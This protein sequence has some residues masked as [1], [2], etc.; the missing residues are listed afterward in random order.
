M[1]SEGNNW[2]QYEFTGYEE[3]KV[4]FNDG[5]SNQIPSQNEEGFSVSGEKW[6]YNGTWYNENPVSNSSIKVHY[7]NSENWQN[8]NIYAYQGSTEIKSWPGESMIS[9]GNNWYQYEFT[10]YAELKVIF[11]NNGSNQIPAQN[12][13]GFTVT[14]E[15]WYKNGV[16]Y[17]SYPGDIVIYFYKPENWSKANIYYYLTDSDTGE[18]WPG[19]TMEDIGD[20][21]YKY[22]ITKYSQAKVLF[23]DGNNQI[24]SA[25][26]EGFDVSGFMWYK[27]GQWY[28]YNPSNIDDN[29]LTGDLNGDGAI[30]NND[31]VLLNK[32]L[33]GEIELED[34]QFD[35][36]DVYGDGI[37]DE[38]DK[39]L[40]NDYISGEIEEFPTGLKLTN[41][42]LTYEYDKLGRVVK[43]ISD[44]E[45][46]IEYSYDANGNILR[47]NTVGNIN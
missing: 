36:A 6:Y 13:E 14:K 35:I 31:V 24:P 39:G 29:D 7:Y 2:Y 45:N 3:L 41:K 11:S 28:N 21:W 27:D 33:S 20:N 34:N 17:D 12:E 43:V 23:N 40:I 26:E 8:V 46:Y 25:G 47:I 10:G 1:T 19:V 37:V 38:N 9:E 32:Y 44:D 4:I 5:G 42:K 18:A 22:T 16:W 15:L 30:D